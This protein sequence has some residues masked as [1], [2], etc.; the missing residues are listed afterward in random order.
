MQ[1]NSPQH[2][3]LLQIAMAIH[4][5]LFVF[6]IL[7]NILQSFVNSVIYI[8]CVSLC[9]WYC[10]QNWWPDWHC[11]VFSKNFLIML[12]A[13][14][15]NWLSYSSATFLQSIRNYFGRSVL[16]EKCSKFL[17]RIFIDRKI[18][19]NWNIDFIALTNTVKKL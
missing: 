19:T 4:H 15:H 7:A 6:S 17:S 9:N 13:E 16:Y 2:C 18:R 11:Y 8:A 3:T 5:R 12:I 14:Q 1:H 10:N